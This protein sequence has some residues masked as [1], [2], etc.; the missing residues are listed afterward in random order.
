VS[1]NRSLVDKLKDRIRETQ[2]AGLLLPRHASM[3]TRAV[4]E[5]TLDLRVPQNVTARVISRVDNEYGFDIFRCSDCGRLFS[6]Q[7]AMTLQLRCDR[8]TGHPHLSQAPIFAASFKNRPPTP[9][10]FSE[11]MQR[12]TMDWNSNY[13]IYTGVRARQSGLTQAQTRPLYDFLKGLIEA[14]PARPIDSLCWT[15]PIPERTCEHRDASGYCTFTRYERDGSNWRPDRWRNSGR[16]RLVPPPTRTMSTFGRFLDRYRPI[17]ISEG[18]TKPI[19]I[20]IHD[21]SAKDATRL[22]FSEEEL[23]GISEILFVR[24]LEIFQFTIAL[25]VGLPSVSIRRRAVRLLTD[26]SPDGQEDIYFLSRRLLTEG[27]VVKL[28]TSVKDRIVTE[29]QNRR[30]TA[31]PS[32]LAV[33]LYHTVSH[34]FLKSLPMMSGLDASEFSESFSSTDNE[35]AV[36]DNSPGGIGGVRTLVEEGSGGLHLRRDYIAQ[37][38]NSTDCQLDCSWSCKACLHTGNCGWINRQLKREMLEE[39]VDEQLRDRYFSA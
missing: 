12:V 17:T 20:A 10:P 35:I 26:T 33:T 2:E 25:A 11:V 16:V 30:P 19:A 27:L 14:E 15:C 5:E 31:A 28:K 37:L 3:L 8:C 38:L 22:S 4:D 34:A 24:K 6:F 13:C 29:W 23:R 36:Y 32:T 21:Y 18:S 39:I 1:R 9:I 7:R